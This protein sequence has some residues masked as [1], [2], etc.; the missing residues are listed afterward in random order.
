MMRQSFESGV[1]E[2][3]RREQEQAEVS[4]PSRQRICKLQRVIFTAAET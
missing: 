1:D 2:Q 4:Q 3:E